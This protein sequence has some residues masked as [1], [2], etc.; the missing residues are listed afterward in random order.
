MTQNS[1]FGCHFVTRHNW[2]PA[3]VVH[4]RAA[5]LTITLSFM[6]R[7]PWHARQSGHADTGML[8]LIVLWLSGFIGTLAQP[9]PLQFSDCFSGSNT[10]QK[11]NVS[12]VYAQ[13]IPE[14]S[15]KARLNLTVLGETP[16]TIL[17]ASNGTDPVASE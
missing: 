14:A 8:C 9:A 7:F 12:N 4:A 10:D 15:G 11:L 5:P 1:I 16:Q 6:A 17:G 2:I 13:L 3:S